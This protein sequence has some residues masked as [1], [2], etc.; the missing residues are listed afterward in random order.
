MPP[1]PPLTAAH[2]RW[3]LL[4]LA[5]VQFTHI[6]DFMLLM[7]LGPQLMRDF[8]IGPGRFGALVSAYTF[9]AA[10]S[11]V[12]ATVWL[13]RFNR[14][15]CLLFLY[16]GFGVATLACAFA[17]HYGALLGARLVAGAFGGIAGSQVMAMVSDLIPLERRGGALGIVMSGF[18]LAAVA[19]V[20]TGLMLATWFDW[21]APFLA[22]GGAATVV[23]VALERVLPSLP[24]REGR[25]RP[26]S[27]DER[28][29]AIETTECARGW[30][31]GLR[32]LWDIAAEPSHA[33]ALAFTASLALAGYMV[34]PFIA[35]Y[36]VANVGWPEERLPLLY[37]VGG[38]ATLIT[39]NLFGRLTDRVGRLRLFRWL[40][41]V[42]VPPMLVLVHLPPVPLAVALLV[43]TSMMVFN[44]GRFV[45]ATAMVTAS[46]G[47]AQ[48]GG[49]MSLNA[50]LQQA[51]GG[52]AVSIAAAVVT[53]DGEGRIVGYPRL[54]FAS[55][56]LVVVAMALAARLRVVRQ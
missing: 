28:V 1:D 55:A 4:L 14:K 29:A 54:G 40:A 7:P 42:S 8:G 26:S 32:R 16:A 24:A 19:G 35:P 11:G 6:V 49:F 31:A 25:G 56:A 43:T 53:L 22:L 48:R 47:P 20:P 44:S 2:E 15:H 27:A 45:P 46:V 3:A 12:L 23:W 5:A 17:P 39:T 10:V 21:H 13:D 52:V 9:S 50:A 30:A 37:L 51:A 38:A 41:V 34:F 36:M 18:S 33:R